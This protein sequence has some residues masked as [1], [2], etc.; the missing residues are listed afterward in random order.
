[1]TQDQ[2]A[3]KPCCVY[4]HY[5][6]GLYM[7]LDICRL[8]ATDEAAVLYQEFV[9]PDAPKWVRS[10]SDWNAVVDGVPRFV[11]YERTGA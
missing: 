5:K 9:K 7:V 2:T 11:L 6:G 1:M 3:P 4:Q 10:I 8:E